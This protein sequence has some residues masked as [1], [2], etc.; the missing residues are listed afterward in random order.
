MD[1]TVISDP[2]EPGMQPQTTLLLLPSFRCMHAGST[3]QVITVINDARYL[4]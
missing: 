1:R 3:L 4:E 2:I